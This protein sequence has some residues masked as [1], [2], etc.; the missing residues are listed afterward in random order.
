MGTLVAQSLV[1]LLHIHCH[2]LFFI[3]IINVSRRTMSHESF[4]CLKSWGESVKAK[5]KPAVLAHYA[6]NGT[7][8]PT[9]SNELRKDEGRIGNYFDSFLAKIDGVG[10]VEWNETCDQPAGDGFR[11]WSGIY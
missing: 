1:S 10:D 5:N 9:L 8:W 6:E 11:M 2:L 4:A 7:L 3:K